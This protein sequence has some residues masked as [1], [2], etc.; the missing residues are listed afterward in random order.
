MKKILFVFLVFLVLIS[1]FNKTSF[2]QS[3]EEILNFEVN[4]YINEDSSLDIIENITYD[5]GGNKRHGIYRTIPY[6]YKKSGFNYN[7]RIKVLEVTSKK[8][9]KY[10]FKVYKKQDK[11]YIKIGRSDVFVSG[12]KTYK[13]HYKVERA[14]NYFTDHVEL[15]WNVT[16][17]KWKVNIKKAAAFIT[18]PKG[19]SPNDIKLTCYTGIYGSSE[20]QCSY[21]ILDNQNI[22]F[23]TIRPLYPYQGLTI[24]LGFPKSIV[25]PPSF[26]KNAFWFLADNWILVFFL[27]P[28]FTFIILFYLYWTRG[29]DPERRRPIIPFYEPPHNLKPALLGVIY[30]EKANL[31]DIS[32]TLI[33]L[34]VKGY[35]KIKE[36]EEKSFFKKSKDYLL[37]LQKDFE[38]AIDLN[39]FEKKLLTY[40]FNGL[41][42]QRISKLKNNFF[43]HLKKL[44]KILYNQ[45]V[46]EGYFPIN[47]EKVRKT[48]FLTGCIF[49][50]IGFLGSKFG[51][52]FFMSFLLAGAIILL[53]AGAMPRRTL[54][55]ARTLTEILGFK[56]Y[57]EVAEKDRLKFHNA[58][59]K[60]PEVFEK[61]LPYA[62]ALGVEKEWAKKFDDI[63]KNPPSWYEG[64][65]GK[66]FSAGYLALAISRFN[67]YS[68]KNFVKSPA[69]SGAL[70]FSGGFSGGGF[71]GGGG[72]SW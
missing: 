62:I 58:P 12:V 56:L 17:N 54:K 59:E 51:Y 70:G 34:A 57:L 11:I 61:F 46:K 4:I 68:A 27:I 28:I 15:Y 19:I 36:I 69:G 66:R 53:F 72:G 38:K 44:K 18:L 63:Y 10:P 16:G 33:D 29:R 30:D 14:L 7:L 21:R 1:F 13:I 41:K 50:V 47:P 22:V 37:T 71:G 48:Y 55:G 25:T 35:L 2:A 43:V 40:I 42:Q 5:F 31:R 9:E 20:K 45:V 24:V 39:E 6:K 23:K 49:M 52:G 67:N 60:K 8:G 3:E 64:D 26:I 32:A 65:F